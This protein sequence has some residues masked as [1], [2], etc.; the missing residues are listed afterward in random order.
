MTKGQLMFVLTNFEMSLSLFSFFFFSPIFIWSQFRRIIFF[1][2]CRR[3]KKR[4]YFCC[5]DLTRDYDVIFLRSPCMAA[6]KKNIFSSSSSSNG[7]IHCYLWTK[8]LPFSFWTKKENQYDISSSENFSM[9]TKREKDKEE[10]LSLI[11]YIL[12]LK[13]HDMCVISV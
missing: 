13:C 7:E 8:F 2:V 3:R 5:F 10:I 4:K 6:S 12:H 9:E 11:K 1:S